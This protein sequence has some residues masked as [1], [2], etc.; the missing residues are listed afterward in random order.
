MGKVIVSTQ[1][2]VDGVIDQTDGGWF[3]A[4]GEHEEHGFDQ[5]RA[6]GPEDVRGRLAKYHRYSRVR[7]PD[8]QPPEVRRLK[9]SARAAEVERDLD[10]R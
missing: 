1:M 6:A 4:E 3:M 2:T 9:D 8:E 10:H 5:L 7:G